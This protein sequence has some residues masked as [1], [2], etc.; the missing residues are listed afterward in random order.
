MKTLIK[1]ILNKYNLIG[2]IIYQN[3]VHYMIMDGF[4]Q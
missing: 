3:L 1:Y 4:D 2:C